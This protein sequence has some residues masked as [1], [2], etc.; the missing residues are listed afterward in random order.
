MNK[1]RFGVALLVIALGWNT[2]A[3]GMR[4]VKA[5]DH[6]VANQLEMLQD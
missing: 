4:A 6:R 3:A 5:L 2:L 1:I